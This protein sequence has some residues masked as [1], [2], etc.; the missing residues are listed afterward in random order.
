MDLA[1]TRLSLKLFPGVAE[2]DKIPGP[3]PE[4]G[5]GAGGRVAEPRLCAR[6]RSA[7]SLLLPLIVAGEGKG[8]QGISFQRKLAALLGEGRMRRLG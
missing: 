5:S 7:F 3:E 6:I 1:W 2:S 4:Q 8:P